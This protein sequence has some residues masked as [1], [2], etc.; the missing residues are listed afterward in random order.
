MTVSKLVDVIL[1]YVLSHGQI[2]FQI[3]DNSLYKQ[4]LT[5]IC[6]LLLDNDAMNTEVCSHNITVC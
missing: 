3:F 2:I 5:N 1:V 4:N 6:S